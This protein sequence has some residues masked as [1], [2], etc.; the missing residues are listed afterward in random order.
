ML[1]V[2]LSRA[3]IFPWS[4]VSKAEERGD[5]G[6]SLNTRAHATLQPA[7]ARPDIPAAASPMLSCAAASFRPSTFFS[8]EP[9]LLQVSESC[10]GMGWVRDTGN[11][12]QEAQIFL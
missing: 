10:G 9:M 1:P 4:S 8:S 2:S 7:Q 3:S 5:D 6:H 11:G 12:A